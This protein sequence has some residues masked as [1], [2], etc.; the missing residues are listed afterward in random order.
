MEGS[1]RQIVDP[2]TATVA[3]IHNM[4]AMGDRNRAIGHI[5]NEANNKLPPDQA[6]FK[7]VTPNGSI[8]RGTRS[9]GTPMKR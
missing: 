5:I 6:L 7:Q 4:I 1:E 8:P 2:L 9:A 3:N